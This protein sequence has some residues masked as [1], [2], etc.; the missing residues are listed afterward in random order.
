M[1]V[2]QKHEELVSQLVAWIVTNYA[3]QRP[4][5]LTDRVGVLGESRPTS[6]DGFIPDVY[7]T[8]SANN[9][10]II[11]DAKTPNDLKSIHTRR[12]LRAFMRHLSIIGGGQLIVSTQWICTNSVK[13]ILRRL[14]FVEQISSVTT[15]VVDEVRIG[16]Q[17]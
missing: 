3:T 8:L 16:S 15:A 6:I 2:S 10:I 12:Q 5:I 13:T 7:C 9:F 11:G 4:C 17:W 1:A 14:Q